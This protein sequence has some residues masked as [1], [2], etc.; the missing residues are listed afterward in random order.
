[1]AECVHFDASI[2]LN[3]SLITLSEVG[4]DTIHWIE[5]LEQLKL[6]SLDFLLKT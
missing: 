4:M 2:T 6:T 3:A 5:L 1:M